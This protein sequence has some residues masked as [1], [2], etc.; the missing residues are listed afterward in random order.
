MIKLIITDLDGTLLNDEK[1]VPHEFWE[2]RNT[3]HDIGIQW[4]LASG[5]Q[6]YT[7]AQQFSEILNDVYILAE[8]G[9]LVMLGTQQIHINPLEAELTARLIDQGRKTPESWPILCCR[10]GAYVEDNY[11]PLLDEAKKYYKRL[12]LVDDLQKVED[13]PLK[14]TM[15]DFKGSEEHSYKYF[16]DFE[17]KCRVAVA[18]EI[19]LDMTGLTASKGT[20]LKKIMEHCNVKAEEVMAFGDYLNDREM[21]EVAHHSYAM[22]NSHPDLFDSARNVTAHDNNNDG[23]IHEVK[24]FFNLT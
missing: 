4:V 14:F 6:Y 10:N 16:K 5:R 13:I 22:K 24:E 17:D 20:A 2:L 11:Q 1:Q 8:N 12:E 7:I 3:L 23:V 18:G 9:A 15:C 21:I 19:W